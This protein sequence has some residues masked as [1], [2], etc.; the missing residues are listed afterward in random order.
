MTKEAHSNKQKAYE[1]DLYQENGHWWL[2]SYMFVY[3]LTMLRIYKQIIKISCYKS[4]KFVSKSPRCDTSRDIW[5]SIAIGSLLGYYHTF[6]RVCLPVFI[7]HT[8]HSAASQIHIAD[9]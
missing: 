2:L 8:G 1:H 3:S 9:I 6:L 7:D 4:S 5:N